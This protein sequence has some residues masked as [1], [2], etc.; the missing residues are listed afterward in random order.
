M[1]TLFQ[2]IINANVGRGRY[3]MALFG[4]GIGVLLILSAVQLNHNFSKLLQGDSKAAN[5]NDFLV[6]SKKI[7]AETMISGK[8][9]IAFT[10]TE[11]DS[12]KAQNFTKSIAFIKSGLF[13]IYAGIELI[14]GAGDIYFECVPDK[15]LDVKTEKFY[16]DSTSAEIPIIIPASFLDQYNTAFVFI[17]NDLPVLSQESLMKIP[18]KITIGSK[19][20]EKVMAGRIVGFSDRIQSFL[21]PESFMDWGNRNF[22]TKPIKKPSRIVLETADASD[23]RLGNYL[24]KEKIITNKDKTRFGKYKQI[25]N[26]AVRTISVIGLILMLFALVIFGLFIQLVISHARHDI[27]LLT[28]LGTAPK[29]LR[30]FLLKKFIPSMAI[31]V[32]IGT[33]IVWGL[34]ILVSKFAERLMVSLP[35]FLALTTLL[36]AL[37]I[38]A[39]LFLLN[40]SSIN[41]AIKGTLNK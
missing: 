39:V 18:I 37:G 14:K 28:T 35:K 7:T 2:K 25:V 36:C 4:L 15:Y 9:A 20:N 32:A 29:Q 16:W 1:N 31:V 3:L 24:D 17:R 40:Y 33:V 12:L 11:V 34:Q 6:L 38:V 22:A 27:N 5:S 19:P 8:D 21:V 10:E 26:W 23:E 13:D 41:K 30:G